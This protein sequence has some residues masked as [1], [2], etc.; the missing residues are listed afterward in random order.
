MVR[1]AFGAVAVIA[2]VF[3]ISMPAVFAKAPAPAPINHG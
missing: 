3:G 2:I 1:D